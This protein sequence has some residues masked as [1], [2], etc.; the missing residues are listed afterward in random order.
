MKKKPQQ[1]VVLFISI[2][3]I[4]AAGGTAAAETL[5][6]SYLQSAVSQGDSLKSLELQ[7]S[8]QNLLMEQSQL[9]QPEETGVVLS[10]TQLAVAT[11][12]NTAGD[13]TVTLSPSVSLQLPDYDAAVQAGIPVSINL[14]DSSVSFTPSLNASA[15]FSGYTAEESTAS[16]DLE[17]E[18]SQLSLVYTYENGLIAIEQQVLLA[19]QELIGYESSLAAAQKSL[20]DARISLEN[21]FASGKINT[22]SAVWERRINSIERLENSVHR[23]Q[24][25]YEETVGSFEETVGSTYRKLANADIPQP[26]IESEESSLTNYQVL[27]AA[28]ELK[29]AQQAL[30]DEQNAQRNEEISD[31]TF[32]Y[33][34]GAG[35]NGS[36]STTSSS[37]HTLQVSAD[38][39]N[40][41]FTLSGTAGASYRSGAWSPTVTV[42]GKWTPPVAADTWDEPDQIR[43][44]LLKNS[45]K[46]AELSYQQ[47]VDDF[48]DTLQS[49]E[50][51]RAEWNIAMAELDLDYAEAEE[52]YRQASHAAE[53]G[54][55]TAKA[56]ADA[57]FELELLDYEYRSLLIDGLLL[58]RE[59]EALSL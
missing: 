12:E 3:L 55:G 5:L 37:S 54:Y 26:A 10:S 8:R 13:Q 16:D 28:L 32:S 41:E 2:L 25:S 43:A 51:D 39:S 20:S 30:L 40:R 46:L 11:A 22:G 29:I 27:S 17:L 50:R 36:Y 58:E 45:V 33:T 42:S 47:S 24:M 23:I 52:T 31:R 9:E 57:A 59:I 14:S 34:A 49:I 4:A 56:A 6:E 15:D 44:A 1:T 35:Y 18:A 7:Q 53:N 19:M 38:A 21:D 48:R